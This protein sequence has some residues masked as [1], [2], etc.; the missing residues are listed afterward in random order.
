MSQWQLQNVLENTSEPTI[1]RAVDVESFLVD[2][3]IDK[4]IDN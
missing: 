3:F 1:T 2:G 4:L